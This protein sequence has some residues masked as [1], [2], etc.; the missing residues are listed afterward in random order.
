MGTFEGKTAIITSGGSGIGRAL[1]EEMVAHRAFVVLADVDIE[2]AEEAAT[3]INDRGGRVTVSIY[4]VRGRLVK[5][6][7]DGE[8]TPGLHTLMWHGRNEHSS[9][10]ASGIYFVR[11]VAGDDVRVRKAILLK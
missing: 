2:P 5:H 11:M 1:G 4:D 7:F 10:T 8:A 6:I 3:A 9:P